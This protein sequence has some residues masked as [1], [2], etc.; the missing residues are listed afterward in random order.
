MVN[1]IDIEEVTRQGEGN[2]QWTQIDANTL[3]S[4]SWGAR[5]SR[6]PC[7]ASR[8]THPCLRPSFLTGG[9]RGAT[10][11]DWD[12]RG[13]NSRL[14][15]SICGSMLKFLISGGAYVSR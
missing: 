9:S 4:D 8:Q 7:L 14:L 6:P 3:K 11:A 2:R 15:A 1:H 12:G 13:L 10:H 5:S